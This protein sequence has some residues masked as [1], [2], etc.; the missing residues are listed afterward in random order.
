MPPRLHQP[1]EEP[2]TVSIRT[3]Q[4]CVGHTKTGARCKRRTA[5][6][7]YCFAH[8]E[9]EQHLKI[10]PSRINGAGMGLYTTIRRQAHR[11]VA[12]YTGRTITRPHN[13]Y[14]GDYVIQLTNNSPFKY[15]DANHTTSSSGRFAN[16]ARRRDHLTNNSHLSIDHRDRNQAKVVSSRTIP[17]GSEILARYG[18][19][20]WV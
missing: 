9:K 8:L 11:M 4:Q 18:N 17:A 15:V 10:K 5:R 1:E 13:T 3:V 19:A 20:Y 7:P 6:T 16:N 14:R 12:P 2:K